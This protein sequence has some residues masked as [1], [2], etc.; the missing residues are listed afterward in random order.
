MDKVVWHEGGRRGSAPRQRA[1]PAPFL[2]SDR[3]FCGKASETTYRRQSS[4]RCAFTF[5]LMRHANAPSTPPSRTQTSS[6]HAAY[7][8][9]H[10]IPNRNVARAAFDDV[11][12]RYTHRHRRRSLP[13][14]MQR[15]P[16]PLPTT[17]SSRSR[18]HEENARTPYAQTRHDGNKSAACAVFRQQC[19]DIGVKSAQKLAG[20]GYMLEYSLLGLI[21]R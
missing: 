11:N 10:G 6:S 13:P 16:R 1:A 3:A 9:A 12:K 20:W 5:Y 19:V 21:C 17:M 18:H 4:S 2:Y 8:H 7:T 14:P 15:S